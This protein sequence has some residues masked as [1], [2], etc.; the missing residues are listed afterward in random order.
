MKASYLAAAAVLLP[1]SA[2]PRGQ[3]A[4]PPGFPLD[5]EGRRLVIRSGDAEFV[6]SPEGGLE[7]ALVRGARR[8]S[9][10][11]ADPDRDEVVVDGV[12]RHF[13]LDL[14]KASWTEGGATL[15][16]GDSQGLEETETLFTFSGAPGLLGIR[17]TFRNASSRPVRLDALRL[18]RRRVDARRAGMGRASDLWSF[19]GASYVWGQDEVV[20]VSPGLKR[21]NVLATPVG[22]SYGGGVPVVA[23]W[24]HDV[25]VALG[26]L[27]TVPVPSALPVQAGGDGVVSASLEVKPGRT[28]GPGDSYAAPAY[29]LSV[30]S[31]DFYEP[32]RLYSKAVQ[33]EGLVLRPPSPEAYSPSWCGWGYEFN[34]TPAQMVGV[35]PKLKQLGIPW[36]TLDDRWFEAYGDWEPRPDTFPGDAIRG[37]VRDYHRAGLRLQLWWVPLVAEDGQKGYDSHTYRVSKVVRDHPDWLILDPKGRHARTRRGL[38]ALCPAL[39]EVQRYYKELTE[40]F[41]SDWDFDGSKLDESYTAPRCFNPAH[42]HA[43]P[44]DSV[45][46]VGEIYRI[47]RDTTRALKPLGVTQICSCGTTPNIAWL[48]D[49]DQAVTADPVGS[50]QVRHRIKILKALLG[51][52]AAVYG[53]HVELTRVLIHKGVESDLGEDFASTVGVGGVVGTKFVWPQADPR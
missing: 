4:P 51:P 21:E 33:A 11:A 37:L 44:D 17:T 40:R 31:G 6:V 7:A 34:V 26:H 9:L 3:K 24:T 18:G 28:L 13:T 32:L 49:M 43:S 2:L 41:I 38:A 8:L 30:Y 20:P 39:P 19:H 42:H 36:G 46:A 52:E 47:I 22:D 5:P 12:R 16:G 50:V 35:I 53:D 25:G 10:D 1:L 15:E 45:R 29:F 27:E 23:F 48:G 14:G